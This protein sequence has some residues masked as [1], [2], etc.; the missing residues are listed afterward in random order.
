MKLFSVCAPCDVAID[1]DGN[2]AWGDFDRCT[3]CHAVM[4]VWTDSGLRNENYRRFLA[5]VPKIEAP[6]QPAGDGR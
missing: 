1:Y 3:K 4:D 2:R 6:G 5:K